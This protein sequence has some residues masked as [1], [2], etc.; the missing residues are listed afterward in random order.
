MS[1]WWILQTHWSYRNVFSLSDTGH[2]STLEIGHAN[3]VCFA[4]GLLP[5][6]PSDFYIS[7]LT[8]TT[9]SMSCRLVFHDSA[10]SWHWQEAELVIHRG[11]KYCCPSFPVTLPPPLLVLSSPRLPESPLNAVFKKKQPTHPK[12]KGQRSFTYLSLMLKNS[13]TADF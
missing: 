13:V 4:V 10:I 7:I 5:P 2:L 9:V 8:R 6:N 3:G 12:Q 1:A 11:G